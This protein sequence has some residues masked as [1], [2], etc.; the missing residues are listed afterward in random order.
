MAIK[1]IRMNMKKNTYIATA[2]IAFVLV[3][4]VA[5]AV[6]ERRTQRNGIASSVSI[7]H[8]PL[9]VQQGSR[10]W[11]LYRSAELGFNIEYPSDKAIPQQG[12][13]TEPDVVAFVSTNLANRNTELMQVNVD[14]TSS[15]DV[16]QYVDPSNPYIVTTLSGM[17]A[18]EQYEGDNSC[19]DCLVTFLS[20]FKGDKYSIEISAATVNNPD[21]LSQGDIEYIRQSFSV[22]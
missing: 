20:V 13:P 18:T 22:K 11:T 1:P 10:I 21:G 12:G 4:L 19:P 8:H 7:P 6:Y 15:S 14:P 3:F 16:T 17:P 9:P 2:I 5:F